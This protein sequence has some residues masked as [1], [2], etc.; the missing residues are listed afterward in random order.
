MV[1]KQIFRWKNVIFWKSDQKIN[2]YYLLQ[3]TQR[4]KLL[5][6][7]I[8]GL[9]IIFLSPVETILHRTIGISNQTLDKTFFCKKS[10]HQDSV[11][12]LKEFG[13]TAP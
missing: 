1:S 13:D 9:N 2:H 3:D 6:E 5:S 7:N 12:L 4:L 8:S 10:E 11:L